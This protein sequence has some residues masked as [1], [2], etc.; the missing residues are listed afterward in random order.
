MVPLRSKVITSV[1]EV[2]ELVRVVTFW[3]LRKYRNR[4]WGLVWERIL[5]KSIWS[6]SYCP[7]ANIVE[8]IIVTVEDKLLSAKVVIEYIKMS[9]FKPEE[10]MSSPDKGAFNALW[11]DELI[12]LAKH[13]EIEL[14]HTMKKD[15]IRQIIL[16]RL[17]NTKV[18]EE[19]TL[20]TSSKTMLEIRKLEMQERLERGETRRTE[21]RRNGKTR[22]TEERGNGNARKTGKGGET[23][24]TGK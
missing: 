10:F 14:K 19:T 24:K 13:L 6:R 16:N 1:N 5:Q 11:K 15:E 8:K 20:K 23:G 7:G 4:N 3:W 22:E 17:M 12:S 2:V 21:E 9:Q 18:F